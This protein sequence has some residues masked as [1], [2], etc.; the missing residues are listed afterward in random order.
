MPAFSGGT[1]GHPYANLAED[2]DD[3]GVRGRQPLVSRVQ[4]AGAVGLDPHGHR[5]NAAADEIEPT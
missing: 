3:A 5:Q 2:R 1:D 4:L